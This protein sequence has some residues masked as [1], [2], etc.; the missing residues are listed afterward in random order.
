M[1]GAENIT[2]DSNGSACRR[3]AV[4]GAWSQQSV[5]RQEPRELTDVVGIDPERQRT[6]CCGC[7]LG[8]ADARR[9]DAA[10]LDVIEGYSSLPGRRLAADGDVVID[11][12]DAGDGPDDALGLTALAP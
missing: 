2:H 1:R 4:A 10:P 3:F 11:D 6:Q 8:G 5:A 7:G 12:G 9:K